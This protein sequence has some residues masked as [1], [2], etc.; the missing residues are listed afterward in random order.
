[1]YSRYI[2]ITVKQT[3]YIKYKEILRY[4]VLERYIKSNMKKIKE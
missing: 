3:S 2:H 1:M 4:E